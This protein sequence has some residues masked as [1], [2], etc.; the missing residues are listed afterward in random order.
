[1]SAT[2]IRNSFLLLLNVITGIRC[3]NIF[4]IIA[5]KDKFVSE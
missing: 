5:V 4:K 2:E 3:K 1:M